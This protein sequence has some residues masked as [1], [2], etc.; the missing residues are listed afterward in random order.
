MEKINITKKEL[1]ERSYQN[2]Y[3][4]TGTRINAI[5]FDRNEGYYIEDGITKRFV[6]YKYMV[7]IFGGTKK[8]ALDHMHHWLNNG[9]IGYNPDIKIWTAATDMQRKKIP[10]GFNWSQW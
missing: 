6:G 5:W 3:T 2:V 7:A 8:Q 9:M 1:A 10:L 4:G